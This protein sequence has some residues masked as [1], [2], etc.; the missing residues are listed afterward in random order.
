[1]SHKIPYDLAA[2][3]LQDSPIKSLLAGSYGRSYGSAESRKEIYA[4]T[5]YVLDESGVVTG[6]VEFLVESFRKVIYTG[7]NF[8][9][10]LDAYNAEP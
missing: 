8:R 10:A 3:E 2:K 1:M 4:I 7:A 6:K 5:T 9:E